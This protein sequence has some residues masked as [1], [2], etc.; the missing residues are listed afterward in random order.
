MAARTDDNFH[1]IVN[2]RWS[3]GVAI[4]SGIIYEMANL[5][6]LFILQGKKLLDFSSRLCGGNINKYLPNSFFTISL[7]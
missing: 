1:V 3:I 6:W 2:T 5:E 7:D 4:M